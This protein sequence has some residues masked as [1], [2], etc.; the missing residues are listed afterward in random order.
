[1]KEV[2]EHFVLPMDVDLSEGTSARLVA[3]L[4]SRL[5]PGLERSVGP[6]HWK[7][8]EETGVDWTAEGFADGAFVVVSLRPSSRDLSF[9]V[10]TGL[11]PP[12]RQT[13]RWVVLLLLGILGAAVVVG[14]MKQSFG[15]ALLTLIAALALWIGSDITLQAL[16]S[17]RTDAAFDGGIWR[18][19]FTDAIASTLSSVG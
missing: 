9:L 16:K 2:R 1:M 18:R 4:A 13:P 3:G 14:A 8:G 12:S 15:W 11:T 6:I 10:R 5:A 19:R 7:T 17:R